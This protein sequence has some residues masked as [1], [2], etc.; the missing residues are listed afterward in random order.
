MTTRGLCVLIAGALLSGCGL[1]RGPNV[2]PTR[3]YV[4][5]PTAAPQATAASPA[6]GLGPIAFPGYLDRPGLATRVDSN[7]IF[8]DDNARWAEP[9]KQNFTRVLATNL[10]HLLGSDR[11]IIFPWY[12][13]TKVD[14][15][16]TLNVTRF[17]T[18]ADGSVVLVAAWTVGRDRQHPLSSGLA[19]L[20]RA[21]G[22]A[23][24]VAAGLS[25]LTAELAQQLA[26]AIANSSP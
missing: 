6:V 11:V 1:L 9:L 26:T 17:E 13:T 25:A 24:Q 18:Q 20:K 7:Q 5:T 21:G 22:S 2:T 12:R 8:Y 4:L 19:D 15:T 3:F 14:Y 23:E 10:S 16:V